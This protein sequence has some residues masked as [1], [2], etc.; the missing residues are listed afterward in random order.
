MPGLSDANY[1]QLIQDITLL[2][3]IVAEHAKTASPLE[4]AALPIAEMELN[5]FSKATTVVV[6]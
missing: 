4:K 5:K 1:P 3:R 2:N 6:S